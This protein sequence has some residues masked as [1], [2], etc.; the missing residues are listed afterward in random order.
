MKK[1]KKK[2]NWWQKTLF[3]SGLT[4]GGIIAT[5][6]TV[7]LVLN[8]AKFGIY[9]DYYQIRELVCTNHGLNDNFVSQGT[10]VTD[11]G[12]Y[13]ITSG[14]MI[15]DTNSRI[16]ITDIETDKTH[17]VKLEK[18]EGKAA[19]YHA[20]GIAVNGDTIY[21]ASSSKIFTVSLSEALANDVVVLNTLF[22]VNNN[23]S[24]LFTDDEYLY[25]GEYCDGSE[26]KTDNT[27]TYN[28][29]T[30]N[31]IVE[32]YDLDSLQDPF[33]VYFVRNKVQGFAVNENNDILLSTSFGLTSSNFYYY[34]N[35]KI[36]NT[37]D[38][39]Y[40][41]PIYVLESHDYVLSGPAMSEDLDYHNG[42]FYTNFESACNK[43]IYGKFILESDKIVALDF[44]KIVK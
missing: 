4:I 22:K 31:A 3:I 7:V 26:Y 17:Y 1:E 14:Y 36:V 6:L 34:K 28:D 37:N 44:S 16:Y 11:D 10:C 30:Y 2:M 40:N 35:A 13:V 20:G 12:K 27:Y 29:V 9:Y 33:A 42:K 24:Y 43:Y 18:S 32:K 21:I 39:L 25:V 41:A 38:T 23:A 15:D 5:A 8:V 19:T